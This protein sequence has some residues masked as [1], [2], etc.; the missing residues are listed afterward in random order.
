MHS[1]NLNL[2]LFVKVCHFSRVIYNRVETNERKKAF[3]VCCK[4]LYFPTVD[5]SLKLV[6]WIEIQ[7]A[8]GA[9]KICLSNME[10]HPNMMK[11]IINNTTMVVEL[12]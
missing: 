9:D 2:Q 12:S 11:A 3:A 10:V 1:N 4:D 6:E 5:L 7:R 8:L